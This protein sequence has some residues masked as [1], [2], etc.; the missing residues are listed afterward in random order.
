V[1]ISEQV[2]HPRHY[3]SSAAKCSKCG[4]RIECIDVVEHMPYSIGSA[5]KYA[6][7]QGLKGPAIVDLKKAIWFLQREV[8]RLERGSRK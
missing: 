1:K 6:W 2:D 4:T 7:R 8:A 5:M 3:I